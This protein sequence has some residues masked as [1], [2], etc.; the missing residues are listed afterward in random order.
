[1]SNLSVV[2]RKINESKVQIESDDFDFVLMLREKFSFM[3][4]NYRFHPAFKNRQWD[5]RLYLMTVDG[6][7]PL[8]LYIR[9]IEACKQ[10]NKQFFVDPAITALTLDKNRLGSFIESLSVCSGGEQ[11][12]PYDYQVKATHHALEQQRC[13]LLSPT[14]SGKSLVIYMLIRVYMKMYPNERFLIMVPSVGLV[15]QLHS[16]FKDY[17]SDIDWNPDDYITKMS[18]GELEED[19]Q[20][21]LTTY[22]SM[23]NKKT[24]PSNSFFEEF[25]VIIND[26]VHLAAAKSLTE[27]INKSVNATVRIG[28][29]GTLAE[30]KS[31]EMS[32]VGLFGEVSEVITTKELMDNNTV[33]NLVIQAQILKYPEQECKFLRSAVRCV[34]EN[35]NN[36]RKKADY[37]E[38]LKYI[39]EH[40][41]RNQYIVDLADSL[42]GNTIIMINRIEHGE[43]L[44]RM[45][46]EQTDR[47]VYLY[48]GSVDK[49]T[50]EEIRQALELEDGSI[51]VGSIGTISTG[52]SI[53][54][55][56]NLILGYGN[57]SK[58]QVL[59]SVGRLLRLSKFSNEVTF[60]DLVDDYCIG[61]YKNYAYVHGINRTEYYN[62]QQMVM[63]IKH[64]N[65]G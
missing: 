55:L 64:I 25:K 37:I 54:R 34:D 62:Q 27:I 21:V 11:I 10:Q 47:K 33:A 51:I 52:I 24:K 46:K 16:D 7:L 22:Q 43:I 18:K 26:E 28:L 44:F 13:I 3:A 20:I 19:K 9:V 30:S 61:A 6:V 42:S 57:K 8:G 41:V 56:N 12:T 53:K 45:L 32:L 2:I 17:S 23:S 63:Q 39:T 31:N 5:G 29:T 40:E 48:N 50:R 49:E 59:Q 58:V 60:Y 35:G 15:T 14:S 38:E 36:V 4:D 1:M 65:L